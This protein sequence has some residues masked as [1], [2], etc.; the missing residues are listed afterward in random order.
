MSFKECF[1]PES[2]IHTDRGVE[3]EHTS[4]E[5]IELENIIFISKVLK[6]GEEIDIPISETLEK[7]LLNFIT[8]KIN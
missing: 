2:T 3:V 6:N 8:L 4:S 5:Q 7:E 1:Y